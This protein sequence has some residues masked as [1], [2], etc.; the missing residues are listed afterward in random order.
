M[1]NFVLLILINM[2]YKQPQL[3]H[4]CLCMYIGYKLF[5]VLHHK[6]PTLNNVSVVHLIRNA[7]ERISSVF[8]A[9]DKRQTVLL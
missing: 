3:I 1:R 5:A 7:Y 4:S 8:G 6:N 2:S 9:H